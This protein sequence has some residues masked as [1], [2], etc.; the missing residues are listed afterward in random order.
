MTLHL[1]LK[2]VYYDAIERGDKNIEYRDAEY[3]RERI[4]KQWNSNGG[5]I[6]ILHRGY[7]KTIMTFRVKTLVLNGD[8]IELH[9]GER[10]QCNA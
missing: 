1:T 3:W 5:N 9:L 4:M 7:T 2:Y 10:L 8:T 6:V